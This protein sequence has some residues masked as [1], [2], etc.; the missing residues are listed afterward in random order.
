[1]DTCEATN[2]LLSKIKIMDSENASKILGY[3]LIQGLA[4]NDLLSLAFGSQALLQNVVVKTKTHLE[5]STNALSTHS[6]TSSPS[7]FSPISRPSNNYNPF[8]QSSAQANNFIGFAKNPS[9]RSWPASGL[10]N[11]PIAAP[12]SAKASPFLSYDN[13]CAGSPL[14]PPF[15]K[16]GGNSSGDASSNSSDLLNEY[17]LGGYSPFNDELS[18]ENEE[19]MDPMLQFDGFNMNNADTHLERRR[20]SESDACIGIEDGSFGIGLKPSM[21]FARGFCKNGDNCKFIHGG[22][23]G[24]SITEGSGGGVMGVSLKEMDDIY[25]QQHEEKMRI[26]STQQQQRLAYN[27][28]MNF[29]LRQESDTQRMGA[30]SV[31]MGDGCYKFGQSRSERNDLMLMAMEEKAKSASR[32]IY[33]T[34]PADSTFKDE[35]VS[36]Y[37][38]TFG[39]VQD[40][41]I[42]YQQK[43]MFGRQQHIQQQL[44]DKGDFSPGSSP[45]GLDPRGLYDFPL[46]RMLYNTQEMMLRRKLEQQVE[47]QQKMELQGRRLIN[48]QLPDLRGDYFHHHQ[49]SQSAGTPISFLSHTSIDINQNLIS[50]VKNR[51]TLQGRLINDKGDA[52]ATTIASSF[53]VGEQKLKHEVNTTCIQSKDTVNVEKEK[54]Y[55]IQSKDTVNVEK[56]KLYPEGCNANECHGTTVEHGLPDSLFASTKSLGSPGSHVSNKGWHDQ[57]DQPC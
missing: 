6:E 3:I 37:F 31:M 39:P 46:A 10:T 54:L 45:S 32:Q 56:E 24:D 20:F 53:T 14:V 50:E 42:P 25:L 35:D 29:Q 26:K 51:D 15:S 9:P 49:Q 52:S 41:R 11:K 16:N 27:N 12:I 57:T 23:E 40:V 1:M 28:H 33:L 47:L 5:L 34:F 43:R 36:N 2:V 21:S 38:S 13:I 30:A 4:D 17:H 55:S 8:L 7:P 48:L 22:F 19:L 18:P 44:L